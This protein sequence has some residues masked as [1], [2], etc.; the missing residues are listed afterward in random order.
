MRLW[1]KAPV[2]IEK[3][4]ATLERPPDAMTAKPSE[5]RGSSDLPDMANGAVQHPHH[6]RF[7]TVP[8]WDG[9]DV[10]N[11]WP[12][13]R[14][15]IKLW[16]HDT[17]I[18]QEKKG[19][20]LFRSLTGKAALLAEPIEDDELFKETA[21]DFI[22]D[23]FDKAYKGFMDLKADDDYEKA[24]YSGQRER[25]ETFIIF[26]QTEIGRDCPV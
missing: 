26:V 5:A 21:V 25:G 17:D 4:S 10:R 9:E 7:D 3:G 24:F 11:K 8:V 22:V 2:P 16:D 19:A 15:A 12:K 13:M 1:K 14:R 20:R 23:Y 6:H 18:P